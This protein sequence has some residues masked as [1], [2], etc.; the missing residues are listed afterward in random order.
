MKFVFFALMLAALWSIPS[1]ATQISFFEEFPNSTTFEKVDLIDFD[2]KIYLAAKNLS[3][4]ETYETWLK[5]A[6]PR[7]R[8]V[9]YW[10]VLEKEEGY[11]ISPW[12]ASEGLERVLGEIE[13]RP[14]KRQISVM[15]DLEPSL[16]RSRLL[17]FKDFKRNK[18]YVS[19]FVKDAPSMN[20][21]VYTVEKSYVPEF[22][23]EPLG[24]SYNP[25][26]YGNK[27]MKMFYSSFRRAVMPDFIVNSLFERKARQYKEK[28]II[29]GL[30]CIIGGI[31]GTEPVNNPEILKY[32]LEIA[33]S[34]GLEEVV[35]FRLNGLNNEYLEALSKS[36]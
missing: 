13:S 4:F 21:N 18:D 14:G 10:P 15:L 25:E 12:A 22:I 28:N 33:N 35:I 34:L 6:N 17:H 1:M 8:D 16:K 20:I 32:E 19:K 2:T 7:V 11:W 3:E 5:V 27:K 9:V 36:L 30:G 26:E 31:H 23:L 24:L 29:M